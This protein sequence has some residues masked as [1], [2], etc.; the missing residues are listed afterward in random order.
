M[1]AEPTAPALVV[2]EQ[3][4][5]VTV[6]I[7]SHKHGREVTVYAAEDLAWRAAGAI[8][9]EELEDEVERDYADYRASTDHEEHVISGRALCA[10]CGWVDDADPEQAVV[11]EYHG[12]S[13]SEHRPQAQIETALE[14]GRYFDA[15]STYHEHF[16]GDEDDICV[17]TLPVLSGLEKPRP[18]GGAQ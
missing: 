7:W 6:L 3:R 16:A 2:L 8:V 17:E 9:A 5:E 15:V 13:F 14:E 11:M 18:G 1:T 4:L 12:D 10:V